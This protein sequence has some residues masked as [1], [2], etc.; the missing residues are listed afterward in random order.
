MSD[1]YTTDIE[2][3][4]WFTNVPSREFLKEL[5]KML[6]ANVLCDFQWTE[7]SENEEFE[8]LADMVLQHLTYLSDKEYNELNGRES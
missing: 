8:I 6:Q 2:D 5:H 4:E 3:M 1:Y 7:H